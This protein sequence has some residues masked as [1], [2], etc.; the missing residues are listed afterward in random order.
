MV[1]QINQAS[2]AMDATN[3]PVER[4][5]NPAFKWKELTFMYYNYKQAL[6]SHEQN[7]RIFAVIAE[8]QA[9][10][11]DQQDR[12]RWPNRAL[13]M[14]PSAN[15]STPHFDMNDAYVGQVGQATKEFNA[16]WVESVLKEFNA[17]CTE[18]PEHVLPT[19]HEFED[20]DDWVGPPAPAKKVAALPH[21]GPTGDPSEDEDLPGFPRVPPGVMMKAPPK[22]KKEPA[23]QQER[24]ASMV[25]EMGDET[26]RLQS[27][28]RDY[29]TNSFQPTA[30]ML[31]QHAQ[32]KNQDTKMERRSEAGMA[33]SGQ[34]G[35]EVFARRPSR[36]CNEG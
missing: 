28:Y 24:D 14:D 32:A 1:E 3:V 21:K 5:L 26:R 19:S 27:Y 22:R 29:S 35:S 8:R 34:G 30:N 16:Y 20:G 31:A 6:V 23:R 18:H 2:D 7:C 11:R 4:S 25:F 12:S 33:A 15:G 13:D 17:Y 9:R 10:L 36:D